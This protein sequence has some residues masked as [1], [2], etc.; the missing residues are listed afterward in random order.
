MK[1]RNKITGEEFTPTTFN[2]EHELVTIDAEGVH[3]IA[4]RG[5]SFEITL[6]TVILVADD[7]HISLQHPSAMA[8]YEHVPES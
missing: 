8:D 3:Q 7:G 5:T 1:I 6:G 4:M 2:G